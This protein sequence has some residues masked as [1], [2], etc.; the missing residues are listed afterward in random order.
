[1][2]D[3]TL[4]C[5]CFAFLSVV[6]S[7]LVCPHAPFR[8]PNNN[9]GT[10]IMC[11]TESF[12]C[13]NCNQRLFQGETYDATQDRCCMQVADV[14]GTNGQL[15]CAIAARVPG[16]TR[17]PATHPFNQARQMCCGPTPITQAE[18]QQA[19]QNAARQAQ[20]GLLAGANGNCV[21]KAP[22]G[23]CPVTCGRCNLVQ[24]G[25]GTATCRDGVNSQGI[26]ECPENAFKCKLPV[27]QAFMAKECPLTCG[28]C[29]TTP[30]PTASGMPIG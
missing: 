16:G 30:A 4:L 20:G 19:A 7:A 8:V 10:T 13:L 6:W 26:S 3:I 29:T 11:G 27:W 23:R 28:T 21:D 12:Q 2:Q 18:R 24:N 17:C 9:G 5:V 15:Y 14:P 1:M 22:P 25:G